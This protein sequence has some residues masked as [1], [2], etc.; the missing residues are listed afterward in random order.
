MRLP[1][2]R[3]GEPVYALEVF[4]SDMERPGICHE[5]VTSRALIEKENESRVSDQFQTIQKK[6][7]HEYPIVY[8]AVYNKMKNGC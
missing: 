5:T 6:Y 3:R 1:A 8:S 2:C 7:T 4:L